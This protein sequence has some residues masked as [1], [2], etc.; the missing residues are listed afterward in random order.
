MKKLLVIASLALVA[1]S[2]ALLVWGLTKPTPDTCLEETIEY[3]YFGKDSNDVKEA[4][5]FDVSSDEIYS[6][7][8][9]DA[10]ET[11]IELYEACKDAMNKV[12][13]YDATIIS[14][15]ES[16]AVVELKV[17]PLDIVT[18]LETVTKNSL[19]EEFMAMSTE[20]KQ[21]VVTE[22]YFVALDEAVAGYEQTFEVSMVKEG[23][24]WLI[25]DVTS[26]EQLNST[27]IKYVTNVGTIALPENTEET[28]TAE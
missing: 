12:V 25:Q 7:I 3:M 17:T 5:G 19:T 1:V 9:P 23:N 20:E 16:T 8:N 18:V 28:E 4:Y 2:M 26:I 24:F 21:A 15:E 22:Q 13:E 11:Q 27:C 14:E 6:V 10:T